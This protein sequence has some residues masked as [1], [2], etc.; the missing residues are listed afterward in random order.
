MPVG[1]AVKLND[2][3]YVTTDRKVRLNGE[4]HSVPVEEYQPP[5]FVEQFD[6]SGGQSQQ[7]L[8]GKDS[9]IF[10]NLSHGF[11][12]DRVASDSARNPSEYRR[13]LDSDCD[14][15]RPGD[16]RLPIRSEA[17]IHSGLEVL[18]AMTDFKANVWGLWEDAGSTDIVSRDMTGSTLTWGNGGTVATGTTAVALDLI[19]HKTK[20]HALYAVTNDIVAEFSTDGVTWTAATTPIALNL[21]SDSV[22]AH[23]D[24]DAGL[25]ADIGGELVAVVW[26]E[27]NGTITFYSNSNDGI[28]WADEGVDI[29]SGNGP[30][31]ATVMTGIDNEDKLY[32]CTREGLYEVDTAPGT[33]TTRKIFSLTAHNDNGRRMTVHSDGALWFQQGVDDDS[34]PITYR[35]FTSDGARRF[36]VVPNDFSDGDG[37]VTEM[38]GPIRAMY[39]SGGF[40]YASI[41][42]GKAARQA[43]LVAHNGSGW[44]SMHRHVL[45]NQKIGPV[46]YVS[47]E[48]DGTP[49]LLFPIRTATDVTEV[50]FL[51]QPNANPQ[52]GVTINREDSGYID[53]PFIDGGMPLTSGAWLRVGVS[54]DDLSADTTGEYIDVAYG[55]DGE[56]RT[57]NDDEDILSGTSSIRLPTATKGLGVES[58]AFGIRL[59]LNRDNTAVA[60]DAASTG[61]ESSVTTSITVSHTTGS[62]SNRALLV[63]VAGAD[64][65]AADTIPTGVTYAGNA[66]TLLRSET[67]GVS[68]SALSMGVSIW[69]IADPTTGANDIVASVTGTVSDVVL[70]GVSVANARQAPPAGTAVLDSGSSTS[71]SIT[72]LSGPDD[73]VFDTLSLASMG[74]AQAATVGGSQTSRWNTDQLNILGAGSTEPGA[75]GTSTMSWDSFTNSK[76]YFVMAAVINAVGDTDTPK[77]KDVVI[78]YLKQ[79]PAQEGFVLTVDIA[80]SGKIKEGPGEAV[81]TTLKAA[82]D[83]GTLVKYRYGSATSDQYVKVRDIRWFPKQRDGSRS[84]PHVASDPLIKR[85]GYAVLTLEEVDSD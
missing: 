85:D 1:R 79:P 74:V 72:L 68:G 44:H 33:W 34:T 41:G 55:K 27:A 16:I 75:D 32:V 6:T 10:P 52:S 77:V 49:R 40:L 5:I 39:S 61:A 50:K 23:E 56:A 28:T 45:A 22:T 15:R 21:L 78:T 82:L 12:R 37:V 43:R 3:V 63:G 65:T 58:N 47:G 11:G 66:M 70:G 71:G 30:Q 20:I 57:A 53:F 42:G 2:I 80:A 31:G 19:A 73:L 26:H 76:E 8:R 64:V 54:A 60:F 83:L 81:W 9:Q 84:S 62:G 36:E 7:Q 24:I 25:F 48:D 38:L 14:T 29:P 13:F 67:K 35:M 51:G 17:T 59:T 4:T 18:R 69:Y 46:I